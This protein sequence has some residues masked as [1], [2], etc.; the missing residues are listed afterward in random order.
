MFCR[1]KAQ[2]ILFKNEEEIE[3]VDNPISFIDP[4]LEDPDYKYSEATLMAWD[5]ILYPA[6][7]LSSPTVTFLEYFMA[8]FLDDNFISPK[9]MIEFGVS[10]EFGL[11]SGFL[12]TV[13]AYKLK[14]DKVICL[15]LE[16]VVHQ[17]TKFGIFLNA[18]EGD[19]LHLVYG[20]YV[21]LSLN[22]ENVVHSI[23]DFIEHPARV[24]PTF[25]YKQEKDESIVAN[26]TEIVLSEDI[27]NYDDGADIVVAS[28]RTWNVS[29]EVMPV[30]NTML[31]LANKNKAEV[32]IA[33]T[34]HAERDI[35]LTSEHL[36][37]RVKN[38]DSLELS[39]DMC[40]EASRP[41]GT[42]YQISTIYK[43]RFR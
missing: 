29:P 36:G 39:D 35:A 22:E 23:V 41:N 24:R 13:A 25:A 10:P 43:P 31:R 37:M 40:Y 5:G 17:E 3:S 7:Y 12:S 11:R 15:S 9:T 30:I 20:D 33:H 8:G 1:K 2:K 18:Q 21:P 34:N 38:L 27:W 32:F 28:L 42:V 6:S 14:A 16:P 4:R 26:N 19:A